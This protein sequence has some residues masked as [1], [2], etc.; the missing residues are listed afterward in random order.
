[1]SFIMAS[2]CDFLAALPERASLM[3][4]GFFSEKQPPVRKK[5]AGQM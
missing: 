2:P 3:I 5:L 4:P 1:M